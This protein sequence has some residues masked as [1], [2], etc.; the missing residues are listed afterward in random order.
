MTAG[1]TYTSIASTTVSSD[2][3]SISFTSISGSY[4]D[5]ILVLFGR[6]TRSATDD[7]VLFRLNSDSGNNYS[8]TRLLGTGSAVSSA[9]DTNQSAMNFDIISAASNA[10]DTYSPNIYHIMNYSNTTINK[11]VLNR[12]NNTDAYLI[13]QVGLWRSTAAITRIDLSLG[14]GPNF[15][16]GTTASLYGI[17]AA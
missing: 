9:S 3:S 5:L 4:T 13:A 12:S 10:S 8:R 14:T 15:K 7:T 17:A 1:A 11:T 16:S 2:T 6:S